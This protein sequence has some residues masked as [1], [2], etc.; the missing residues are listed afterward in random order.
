MGENLVCNL[1]Y[2]PQTQVVKG[3]LRKDMCQTFQ[4][5]FSPDIAN[6]IAWVL[7]T[8][9]FYSRHNPLEYMMHFKKSFAMDLRANSKDVD[10]IFV[11]KVKMKMYNSAY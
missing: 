3:I 1:Q 6:I 10:I 2:G 4:P 11:A 9:D 7:A 8:L 5:L